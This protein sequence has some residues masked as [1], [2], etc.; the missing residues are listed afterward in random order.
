MTDS[1]TPRERENER[2]ARRIPEEVFGDGDLDLLDD[3]YAPDA[4]DHNPFGSEEGTE[5]I[6]ESY[7][8]FLSAFPDVAQTVERSVVRGD[9]VALHITSRGTHEGVLWGI[10]PT[11][12][13]IDVQQMA[14]FRLED[15]LIAERW[16]LSDNLTLL[17]QLG[18]VDFST[19]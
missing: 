12:N 13:E 19:K 14:F 18:A 17:R 8:S 11:G 2:T 1:L 10:E 7:E 6:R 4:V 5:A 16:F 15:G 9:T 3:L